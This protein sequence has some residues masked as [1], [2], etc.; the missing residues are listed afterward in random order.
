MKWQQLKVGF[1]SQ[2]A[3]LNSGWKYIVI[4]I[5]GVDMILTF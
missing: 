4:S 1:K 3:V 5:N 2:N